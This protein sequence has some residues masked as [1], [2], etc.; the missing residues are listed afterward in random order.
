MKLTEWISGIFAL[1]VV[2]LLL[3]GFIYLIYMFVWMNTTRE[4]MEIRSELSPHWKAAD[5]LEKMAED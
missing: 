1:A 2:V 5:A 4:G 3:G